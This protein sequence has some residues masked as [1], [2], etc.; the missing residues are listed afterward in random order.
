MH[1]DSQYF[2]IALPLEDC[3]RL[4]IITIKIL[5][6]RASRGPGASCNE[7][8]TPKFFGKKEIN[9]NDFPKYIIYLKRNSNIIHF[10]QFHGA[11][12]IYENVSIYSGAK[13]ANPVVFEK[14]RTIFRRLKWTDTGMKLCKPLILFYNNHKLI[15]LCGYFFLTIY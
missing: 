14:S 1:F 5:A 4:Y 15:C 7:K 6:R 10:D 8:W 11:P 2:E 12:E 3:R 13:L 9:L